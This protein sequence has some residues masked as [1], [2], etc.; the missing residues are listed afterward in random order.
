[1]PVTLKNGKIHFPNSPIKSMAYRKREFLQ[2]RDF[3]FFKDFPF[4]Y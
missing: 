3:V 4:N 1:V 2:K